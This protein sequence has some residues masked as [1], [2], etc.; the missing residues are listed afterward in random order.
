MEIG[1]SGIDGGRTESSIGLNRMD[2]G[3]IRHA[4]KFLRWRTDK[5]ARE[6]LLQVQK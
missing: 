3:K 1:L 5:D 2:S 4:A 6:C